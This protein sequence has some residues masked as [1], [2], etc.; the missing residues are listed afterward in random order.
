MEGP[1]AAPSN[2][3][4]RISSACAGDVPQ[5]ASDPVRDPP[6]Q[7]DAQQQHRQRGQ[8]TARARGSCVLQQLVDRHGDR[9][10]QQPV[11]GRNRQHTRLPLA[12]VGGERE[13]GCRRG[14]R[15]QRPQAGQ[16]G[17]AELDRAWRARR[18]HRP[19]APSSG[20]R[21]HVPEAAAASRT[22]RSSC[23]AML[24]SAASRSDICAR[25]RSSPTTLDARERIA[26]VT[27]GARV[28]AKT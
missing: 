24:R 28:V 4:A 27:P 18:G 21:R 15:R 2:L 9:Q 1:A 20:S 17:F 8:Q 22:A 11:G 7:R 25:V 26:T 13:V 6:G 12:P 10:R 16:Y 3:N 14:V 23:P 5:V 19:R